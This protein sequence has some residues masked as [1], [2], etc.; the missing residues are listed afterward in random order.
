[1]ESPIYIALSRQA[2]LRRELNTVA[3]NIANA[4]TNG[5][6][7]ERTLFQEFLARVGGPGSKQ[8]TS[9]TQDIGQM[10]DTREGPLL[11]T[12]APLDLAIRGQGYLVVGNPGQEMYT[13]AQSFAL[14][15][16][17]F[18]KTA[19]GYPLLLEGG[20]QLQIP[21]NDDRF[22]ITAD[23]EVR[24][25][26]GQLLGRLQVVQ[27]S[28]E[29]QMRRSGVNLWTTDQQALPAPDA[30]VI[31][32]ALEGSNVQAVVEVTRM[33]DMLRDYQSAQRL[34]D[35]ENDRLRSAIQRIARQA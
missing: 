9:M 21:Q 20:Q 8:F 29:Q 34:I 24:S 15:E 31:Q 18:V 13:R 6:R 7:G 1:M 32:G 5:F 30:Q 25:Q 4:S 10:R 3:N 33:I 17:R 28:D 14:D 11:P 27:F 19:D 22:T 2:A 23:G 16:Q 35:Q 12:G 26:A